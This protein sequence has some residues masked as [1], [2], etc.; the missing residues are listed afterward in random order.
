MRKFLTLRSTRAALAALLV[1]ALGATSTPAAD[2]CLDGECGG[3][4]A[5]DFGC[6]SEWGVPYK[7]VCSSF[8]FPFPQC[9]SACVSG[10]SNCDAWC[11]AIS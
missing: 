3:G 4:C 6:N 10:C 1:V 9:G 2:A 7:C 11:N 8:E 5:F